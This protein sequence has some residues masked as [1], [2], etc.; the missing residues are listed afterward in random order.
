MLRRAALELEQAQDSIVRS[1]TLPTRDRLIA[2]LLQLMQR[3]GEVQADGSWHLQ[4][5]LPRRDLASMIAIRHETLSRIIARLESDG[6]AQFSGRNV[7]VPSLQA[8]TAAMRGA[9]GD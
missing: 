9:A 5:P 7:K 8:L 6:L 1:A 4:L 3:H 2:L